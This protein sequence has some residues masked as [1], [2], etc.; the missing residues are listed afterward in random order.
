MTIELGRLEKVELRQAWKHEA[1]DFT[2]WLAIP[3]NL[4][5]LS[6]EIGVEI[7]FIQ[8][9]ASTGKFNVDILAEEQ[10]T[11]RRIVIENQLE[12]TNHDH[13]G[14]IVT[15]ASGFDAEIV[16]WI[17]RDVRD[18]HKRAVD[19]LNEHTD[20]AI[21]F[22][23]IR[24]ELWQIS[25]SAPAPKF[26][27]VCQPNNWAK[28]IKAT[29]SRDSEPTELRVLQVQFWEGFNEAFINS[30]I[31]GLKIIKPNRPQHYCDIRYGSKNSH[32]ALT[33]LKSGEMGCEIYIPDSMELF[34]Q[35]LTF[36][37][38][39]EQEIGQPLIWME[40]P[41]AKASRAKFV[42]S[43]DIYSTDNWNEYYEWYLTQ[44]QRFQ[45]AFSKYST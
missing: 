33:I 22:F 36:K 6:D 29:N 39:I 40:L 2:N 14:K 23:V 16:I 43:A 37:D 13:L 5:L 28:A 24:M 25:G 38:A 12:M 30:G 7:S 15:Y 11:G 31:Q 32:I 19:W 1:L 44:I 8:T 10:Q 18:E 9:E 27:V 34:F 4:K 20:E 45:N 3:D 35:L 21:N 42:R 26:H 17:V 41:T